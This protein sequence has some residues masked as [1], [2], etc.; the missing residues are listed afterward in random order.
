MAPP[1]SSSG[2]RKQPKKFSYRGF[3]IT[4]FDAGQPAMP[5]VSVDGTDIM[6]VREETGGFSAPMLNMFATYP[7]LEDLVR[8]LIDTSPVF[9]A[10]RKA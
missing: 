8:G 10:R 5:Q 9:L 4:V 1:R 6:V 7:S 3:E 2:S